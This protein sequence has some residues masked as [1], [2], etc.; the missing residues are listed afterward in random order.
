VTIRNHLRQRL[1][2]ALLLALLSLQPG[3]AQGASAHSALLR[4]GGLVKHPLILQEAD[5]QSLPR[6]RLAV[7]DEKGHPV[8]YEGVPVAAILRRAG[9]PLGADLRG[10]AM[11][12]Y[13]L[14][15]AA[16]GYAAV[17]ALPEF[18]PDF[19]SRVAIVAD[20]RDGHPIAPPEGPLRLVI[21]GERRH[22]RWVREVTAL[23]L[24]QARASSP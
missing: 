6:R 14:V 11:K 8:S 22:A 15:E 24:E 23:D 19:T 12:L 9:A 20:R 21:P 16:D 7:T 13:L 4:V 18:D 10:P 5:L 17:F 1:A 3:R 2:P